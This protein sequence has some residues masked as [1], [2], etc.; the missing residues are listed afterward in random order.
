MPTYG[1]KLPKGTVAK[2]VRKQAGSGT[3]RAGKPAADLGAGKIGANRVGYGP[4]GGR[5]VGAQAQDAVRN[6]P[7]SP[8]PPPDNFRPGRFGDTDYPSGGR[9]VV[10][11][12]LAA[13]PDAFDN[14]RGGSASRAAFDAMN[15]PTGLRVPG[16]ALVAASKRDGQMEAGYKG[17]ARFA[18]T[19]R[20]EEVF[21]RYSQRDPGLDAYYDR[22]FDRG[23]QRINQQ[24]AAR[25]MH[26]S[27]AAGGYIADMAGQLGAEQANREADY[28][29][30]AMG[31]E[32]QLGQAADTVQ[33]GIGQDY[34]E[35]SR[36]PLNALAALAG[37]ANKG[38][39]DSSD[40][41]LESIANMDLGLWK[42]KLEGAKQ[43]NAQDMQDLGLIIQLAQLMS[44]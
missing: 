3:T 11:P 23:A 38:T 17:K 30:Q 19:N 8:R 5:S 29:L 35:A 24:A 4:E 28:Y 6:K 27:T 26:G 37:E 22:A 1:F 15:A 34:L 13:S 36:A 20:S 40:E 43:G 25:G 12:P 2:Q 39:F 18:P 14:S 9:S 31:L 41:W 10:N 21:Q 42:E 32:G 33:R 7:P 44:G 16:S